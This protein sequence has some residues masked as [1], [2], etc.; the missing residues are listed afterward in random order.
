DALAKKQAAQVV[1][2]ETKMAEARLDRVARRDRR[3]TYNPMPVTDLQKLTPS[4]NWADYLATAGLKNVDQ[5][6]ESMP[7][8]M[9]TLE[10][11]FKMASIDEIKD[12]MR[13]TLINKSTGV[14]TTEIDEANQDY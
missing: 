2:L 4:V 5:V 6:V 3:N 12:D 10:S 7:K 9:E 14:L 8:Y 11:I 13:W 1:A